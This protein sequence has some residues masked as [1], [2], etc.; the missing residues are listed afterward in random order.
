[1]R[2]M[3]IALVLATTAVADPLPWQTNNNQI[4]PW[5]GSYLTIPAWEAQ[6]V[7]EPAH[8]G[9]AF[10]T[11]NWYQPAHNLNVGSAIEREP[12]YMGLVWWDFIGGHEI[13]DE[14]NFSIATNSGLPLRLTYVEL[15]SGAPGPQGQT[16]WEI[17]YQ[18]QRIGLAQFEPSELGGWVTQATFYVAPMPECGSTLLYFAIAGVVS[19][20]I[21]SRISQNK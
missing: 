6:Q 21:F 18:D 19:G 15:T 9:T 4:F 20:V 11:I 16:W 3:L 5:Q 12:Y 1:M 8:A 10:L 2:A 13:M 17:P 14:G 7:A